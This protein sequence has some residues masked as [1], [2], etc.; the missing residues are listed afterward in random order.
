MA[1]ISA[2]SGFLLQS[3]TDYS[4][5]NYRVML[6]FFGLAGLCLL[7]RHMDALPEREERKGEKTGRRICPADLVLLA[8]A[9]A[10]GLLLWG[11]VHRDTA[12]G[13]A[14]SRLLLEDLRRSSLRYNDPAKLEEQEEYNISYIVEM[15]GLD[16]VCCENIPEPGGEICDA[17][18]K[19]SVGTLKDASVSRN[20]DG[21]AD[22]TLTIC[23]YSI[24][25]KK[26]I[27]TPDG[28]EIRVGNSVSLENGDQAYLGSGTITWISH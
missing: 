1:G 6:L 24:F 23:K 21:T 18:S 4:F 28:Y 19:T 12:D 8:A 11:A 27:T 22:I 15:K 25:T 16:P 5:Y 10:A 9:V 2:F 26:S 3:F 13:G 20:P 17:Y 14:S 7:L